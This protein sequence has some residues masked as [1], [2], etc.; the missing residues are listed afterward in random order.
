M[1]QPR[2]VHPVSGTFLALAPSD[3]CVVDVAIPVGLEPQQGGGLW[4]GSSV[5]HPSSMDSEVG[6]GCHGTAAPLPPS[7][8]APARPLAQFWGLMQP[9]PGQGV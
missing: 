1:V 6:L 5:G 3:G 7:L 9:D 8:L 2:H 4:V